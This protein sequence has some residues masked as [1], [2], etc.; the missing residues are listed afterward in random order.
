MTGWIRTR[1]CDSGHCVEMW[2][3]ST[4]TWVRDN[5]DPR[6]VLALPHTDVRHLLLDLAA[7]KITPHA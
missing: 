7:G 2:H 5:T 4:T 1:R 3:G 6:V